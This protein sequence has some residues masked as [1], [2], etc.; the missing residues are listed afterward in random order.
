MAVLFSGLHVTVGAVQSQRV[1]VVPS[2]NII[3]LTMD[4]TV[5]PLGTTTLGIGVSLD[6]G[7]TWKTS[8]MTCPSSLLPPSGKWVM[9]YVLGANDAPTHA[10]IT[11]DTALGFSANTTVEAL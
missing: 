3:R 9:N 6:G 11:V 4:A 2:G 7:N 10:R 5:F 1:L 8:S